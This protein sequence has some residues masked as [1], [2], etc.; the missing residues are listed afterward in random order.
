MATSREKLKLGIQNARE[1]NKE[2]WELD[3]GEV[4]NLAGELLRCI[5][6]SSESDEIM[7]PV[8]KAEWGFLF[9]D[10]ALFHDEQPESYSQ[11]PFTRVRLDDGQQVKVSFSDVITYEIFDESLSGGDWSYEYKSES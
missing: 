2:L 1:A 5:I 7:V 9:Q 6:P 3:E 8:N 11:F 4:R 10:L